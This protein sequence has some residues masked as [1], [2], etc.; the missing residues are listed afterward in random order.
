MP[1]GVRGDGLP[2]VPAP[3]WPR[4]TYDEAM[5][6]YG[7]DRPDTRFGLEI[8]DLGEALRSTEFK[9]F[10]G[11]LSGGRRRARPQRG[12]R[13]SCRAPSSTSSPS[14]PSEY[15]AKG[16]VWAFVEDG[17]GWRSPIAKFLSDDERAAIAQRAGRGPGRPAADRRRPGAGGRRRARASC[18][19]SSRAASTSLPRDRHDLLW[20]VDFP[21]F[22]Q[23]RRDGAGTPLHHPFTAPTGDLDGDPGAL[24]SRA[25]DLVLDGTEIGGGSIRINR[26]DVQQQV[27]E[28]LGIAEEAQAR[29]GFLLDALEYGAP[30]HGGIA[31]GIDRIVAIIAGRDSIRDV[32]AVPEDGERR[33]PADRRSGAGR[34]GAAARGRAAAG[35]PAAR[36]HTGLSG[37]VPTAASTGAP[38]RL[39]ARWNTS[40]ANGSATSPLMSSVSRPTSPPSPT[41]SSSTASA[42]RSSASPARSR[43]A[44]SCPATARMMASPWPVAEIAQRASA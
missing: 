29:F 14:S 30:P 35:R 10:A 25:Y 23:D 32:I 38:A 26:P 22:E 7:S 21:M 3:P 33:R 16:L 37:S 28:L 27:F 9:V 42:A 2:G 15:G 39:T 43:A 4:M 17:G 41:T 31:L 12:R 40:A 34:R 6:R 5:L 8:H 19:S 11:A 1:R 44:T 18:G 20:V 13:A 36:R 24:R